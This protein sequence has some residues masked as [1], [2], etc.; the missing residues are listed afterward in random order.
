MIFFKFF[1]Q[2]QSYV[3]RRQDKQSSLEIFLLMNKK[4]IDDEGL[5]L[6]FVY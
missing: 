3:K 4:S 2:L 1:A 6:L 5:M